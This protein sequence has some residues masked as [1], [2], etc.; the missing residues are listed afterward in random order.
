[1]K[2]GKTI[3]IFMALMCFCSSVAAQTSCCCAIDDQN[4]TIGIKGGFSIPNLTGGGSDN[5]LSSGYSSRLGPTYGAYGEYHFS[6]LFSVSVGAE[7]SSQGGKKDGLQAFSASS[8]LTKVPSA[9]QTIFSSLL[10]NTKYLYADYK[11]EAKI[12]YL[13]IPVLARVTKQLGQSS[14]FSVYAAVGPFLGILLNAKQVTSGSSKIYTDA[15]GTNEFFS[16]L[17]TQSFDNTEDI[18]SDL[19][20]FNVGVEGFVGISYK[21][22]DH[23]ALFVEGGGNFGFVPIQISSDDGKNRTGAGTVTLG[24]AYTF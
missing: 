3:L 14:P 10:G 11:S 20:P 17:G 5:E 9:E 21:L 24:Y 12:N 18:K 7:Y 1:M 22:T 16:A 23:H 2:R 15:A 13:L 6:S 19:H 4:I 8:W